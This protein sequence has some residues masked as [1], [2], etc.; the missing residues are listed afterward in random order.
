M[1]LHVEDVSKGFRGLKA[2]DNVSFEVQAGE[3]SSIIGPNGAGKSTLFNVMTG[4]FP[5][6]T[7][8]V[9][10]KGEDITNLPPFEVFRKGIGRSFQKTNIFH[11]LTTYINIQVA[12]LSGEGRTRNILKPAKGMVRDAT[13]SLLE[14]VGLI[15]NAN[16]IASQMAYGDQRRLEIGIALANNPDF[17]FLDEPTSGVS[18]EEAKDIVELIQRLKEERGLTVLLIEH[19]MDVVFSV[20]ERIRVLHEGRLIFEGKPDEVRKSD[21]VQRIYLGEER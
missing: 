5:P 3:I 2:L 13:E 9:I 21:E 19:H 18:V 10:Y 12:V 14:S 17:V 11:E 15:D 16:H 4:Q 20:S 6:D 7:G 8:K 1:I